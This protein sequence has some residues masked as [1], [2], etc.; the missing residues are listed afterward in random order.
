M[1]P[2]A[3][4]ALKNAKAALKWLFRQDYGVVIPGMMNKEQIDQAVETA[5]GSFDITSDEQKD[6]D[7]DIKMLDKNFC[8][9]C[10]YCLPCPN[11]IAVNSIISAELLFNRSG[12]HKVNDQTIKM[13]RAGLECEKCGI[14]ESRCPYHLP[15]TTLVSE[16]AAR[17]LSKIEKMKQV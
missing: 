11:G 8:R 15:L 6:I 17:L 5:Q 10:Q 12:W 3:G 9:R 4:G 16:T 13:L 2:F 14:C 1:K 7:E